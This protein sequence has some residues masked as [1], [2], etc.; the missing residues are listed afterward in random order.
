MSVR[1][2]GGSGI[3]VAVVPVLVDL[4]GLPEG[5]RVDHQ[6][7]ADVEADVVD[8][9]RCAVEDEIARQQRLPRWDARARAELG[10]RG[11]R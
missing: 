10:L 3:V 8:V 2:S 1:R 11:S 9:A 5:R 6:S 7:A 4:H